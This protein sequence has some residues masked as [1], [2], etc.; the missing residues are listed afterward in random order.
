MG[1]G[2]LIW[3]SAPI[4]RTIDTVKNMVEEGSV[5]EGYKKT[6]KEDITEDNPIGRRE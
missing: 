4:G 3:R 5:V 2:R 6:I 1:L